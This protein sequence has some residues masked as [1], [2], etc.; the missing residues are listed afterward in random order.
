MDSKLEISAFLV[1]FLATCFEA[2]TSL[3][4]IVPVYRH[5]IVNT[6]KI[7]E[8]QR[9]FYVSVHILVQGTTGV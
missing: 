3:G 6:T 4:D 8:K 7:K 1:P 5:L 2:N 9:K